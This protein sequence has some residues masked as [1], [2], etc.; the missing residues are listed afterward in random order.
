VFPIPEV[1]RGLRGDL[2]DAYEGLTRS[3]PKHR[4]GKAHSIPKPRS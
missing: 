2:R 1:R 3:A 4:I